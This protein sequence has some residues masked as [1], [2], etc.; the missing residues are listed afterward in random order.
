MGCVLWFPPPQYIQPLTLVSYAPDLLS[1]VRDER[2]NETDSSFNE[3]APMK[4]AGPVSAKP[5][6]ARPSSSVP[7][8]RNISLSSSELEPSKPNFSVKEAKSASAVNVFAGTVVSS[9]PSSGR[10]WWESRLLVL[11]LPPTCCDPLSRP[12]SLSGPWCL[13]L[14]SPHCGMA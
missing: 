6:S 2:K 12:L 9:E 8:L 11:F 7:D 5:T 10:E 3:K 1:S 4:E 13:P 14:R